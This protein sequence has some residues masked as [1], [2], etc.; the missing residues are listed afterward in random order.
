M[1]IFFFNKGD[2]VRLENDSYFLLFL[3][4]TQVNGYKGFVGYGIREI[5]ANHCTSKNPAPLVNISGP[6]NFT[7]DFLIRAFTSGCYYYDTPNGKWSSNGMEV[8]KETT[9]TSA[10]CQT[11]HLTSFA[12]GL[13]VMPNS[14][15][16]EYVWANASFTRN[17]IIYSSI[18]GLI[19]LYVVLMV[20]A[21]LVDKKDARK[22]N[23]VPLAD[24]V[25]ACE[26]FY[27]VIVFTGGNKEAATNS[28]VNAC[29]FNLN[30][31]VILKLNKIK[32][33]LGTICY[34]W[35]KVRDGLQMPKR[36]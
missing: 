35:R 27:E 3:N 28:K 17:P 10:H 5:N 34:K 4:K 2:F 21:H 20:L 36:E 1:C 13:V 19:S 33:K 22:I 30:K 24:C 32:I 11:N 6:V 9:L 15:N 8:L 16:F 18:I 7:S 25:S 14:I 26:Y 23:L 31:I 29:P 12:G